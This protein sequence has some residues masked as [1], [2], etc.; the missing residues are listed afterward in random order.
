M[1]DVLRDIDLRTQMAGQNRVEMLLFSLSETQRF[2]I[3]V[4]KVREVIPMPTLTSIPGDSPFVVGASELRGQ[5]VPVIDVAAA[6][7]LPALGAT[8]PS[9]VVSEVNRRIQAFSLKSVD[10]IVNLSWD[11]V[12]PPPSG[13]GKKLY[14]TGVIEIDGELIEI[15]DVETV[16]AEIMPM[17][18]EVSES[19]NLSELLS[20]S[21]KPS[22]VVFCDDSMVARRQI[23]S[24]LTQLG[25]EYEV[26]RDGLATLNRLKEIASEGSFPREIGLVISDVEMP[27]MDGYTLAAEIRKDS[28]MGDVPVILHTSLSGSFNEAL[29]KKVGANKFVSKFKPDDLANEVIRL[30]TS[31]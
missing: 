19:V 18:D 30:M 10:R 15:L 28:R 6:I 21:G 26:F 8:A 27:N 13:L 2:A 25:L 12:L 24:V 22:K 5:T 1:S 20:S 31:E 4:F 17:P 29:V 9:V 23:K 11:Q 3:N 16:L 7:G 14:V